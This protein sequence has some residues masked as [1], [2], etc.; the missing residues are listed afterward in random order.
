MAIQKVEY[1]LNG[2]VHQIPLDSGRTYRKKINAPPGKHRG[3]KKIINM[4]LS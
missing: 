4:R 2:Q 1:Y 3:A